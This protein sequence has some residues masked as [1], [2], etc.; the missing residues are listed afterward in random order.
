MIC[1]PHPPHLAGLH[2]LPG[3]YTI[4]FVMRNIVG[5]IA[6]AILFLSAA[7]HSFLGWPELRG[8]LAKVNAPKDLT[9]GLLVGWEFGGFTMLLLALILGNIFLQR[10]KGAAVS[11]FPALITG[12]GYVCFGLWAML[13]VDFQPFYFVFILPGALLVFASRGPDTGRPTPSGACCTE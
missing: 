7:A 9:N 2:F 13:G 10:R 3:A 4:L 5:F 11:T 1:Q 8:E 6:S 12:V